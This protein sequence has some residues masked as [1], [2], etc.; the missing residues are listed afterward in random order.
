MDAAVLDFLM[1]DGPSDS[2]EAGFA[3]RRAV[4]GNA[5]VDRAMA[6]VTEFTREFQKIIT[7]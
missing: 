4:F 6:G 5:H 1:P 7:H 3:V 2:M